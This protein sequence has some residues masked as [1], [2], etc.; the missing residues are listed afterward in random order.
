MNI[1][2]RKARLL[3]A[4]AAI[5]GAAVLAPAIALAAPSAPSRPATAAVPFC[6]TPGLVIW[7]NTNGDAALGTT[8]YKLEFTNLSGHACSLN[9]FPFMYG[10]NLAGKQLGRRAVFN[11]TAHMVTIR[12]GKTVSA[13]LGIVVVQN[14]GP[15]LNCSPTTAAGFKVFPPNQTRA[16]T[17]PFPFGACGRPAGKGPN[18]LSIGPVK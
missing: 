8:Y 16:K 10:V 9:G 18:Y 7:L 1:S 6:E 14:F 12:N 15:P 13:T 2:T 5:A 3:V 17:V 4:T 11:G